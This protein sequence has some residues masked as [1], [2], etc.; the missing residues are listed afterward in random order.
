MKSPG[1][2]TQE[3]KGNI[4]YALG[5]QVGEDPR[6]ISIFEYDAFSGRLYFYLAYVLRLVN[7]FGFNN[8]VE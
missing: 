4:H 8:I 2:G 7:F 6:F 1:S 5:V 3:V